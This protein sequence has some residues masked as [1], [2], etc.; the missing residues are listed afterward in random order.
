MRRVTVLAACVLFLVGCGAASEEDLED[1]LR[2][3]TVTL[4]DGRVA[5]CVIFQST[6]EGGIWCAL[7]EEGDY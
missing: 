6:N 5:E 1:N 7:A 2:P 3:T 4:K